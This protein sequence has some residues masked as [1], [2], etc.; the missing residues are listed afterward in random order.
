MAPHCS[1]LAWKIPWME[2][3]GGLPSMGSQ[4]VGHDWSDLVAAAI[5]TYSLI[6]LK[7][8]LSEKQW[9]GHTSPLNRIC[10]TLFSSHA[11]VFG[12]WRRTARFARAKKPVS[13]GLHLCPARRGLLWHS[14]E[15]P[16][17]QTKAS[18]PIYQGRGR[19]VSACDLGSGATTS[20]QPLSL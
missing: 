13:V 15:A 11:T 16:P 19:T 10:F 18:M 2:E 4:R 8:I 12:R 9:T 17:N 5:S 3:P 1:T 7:H 6:L 20:A 14:G